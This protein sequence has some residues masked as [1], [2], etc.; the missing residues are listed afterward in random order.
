LGVRLVFNFGASSD[1]ARQIV[2]G[3][4][5]DVFFS[6]DESW[7]DQVA[8]AGLLDAGSRRSPL[9]NRLAVVVPGSSP[10]S[11]HSAGDLAASSVRRLS[12][13]NPETVPAGKYARAWLRK[14][15]VWER[16]KERVVPGVDVRAALAAVESGAVEAGVVYRTDAAISRRV[17]VAFEVPEE[18][19][20]PISYAV[21][22]L[23]ERPHLAQAR[24][25]AGWL[26]GKE[27]AAGFRNRGF[28]CRRENGTGRP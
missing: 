22:A 4:K 25:V 10:L 8:E 26:A 17:R 28:I 11:L 5:A 20:P 14:A 18:E 1:L 15:G 16:L 12:L 9:S 21:A 13:A 27:A 6:A 24:L 23:K 7:I 3:N 19:A 2:A